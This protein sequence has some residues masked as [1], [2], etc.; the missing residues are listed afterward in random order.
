M[1]AANSHGGDDPLRADDADDA[2]DSDAEWVQDDFLHGYPLHGSLPHHD[3]SIEVSHKNA[4]YRLRVR[5]DD[6]CK[7]LQMYT[8]YILQLPHH[9]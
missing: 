6:K 7:V 4:T 8:L 3:L 2:V 5:D 9:L 1:K